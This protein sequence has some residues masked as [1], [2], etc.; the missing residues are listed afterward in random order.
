MMVRDTIQYN[1]C[2]SNACTV[3]HW[4]RTWGS[5]I[6][7]W[8]LPVSIGRNEVETA[9][10]PRVFDIVPVESCL[11]LIE[12]LKL[13]LH[14]L[15]NRLTTVHS[16]PHLVNPGWTRIKLVHWINNT[17]CEQFSGQVNGILNKMFRSGL[18]NYKWSYKLIFLT[19]YI[20]YLQ[21]EW[22][23]STWDGVCRLVPVV[24]CKI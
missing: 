8:H 10:N 15:G 23:K 3:N 4:G 16:K 24:M 1:I 13:L 5:I 20:T 9:V 12:L 2:T 7:I 18:H 22:L 11:V 19:K 6:K 14:V 17:H 21:S